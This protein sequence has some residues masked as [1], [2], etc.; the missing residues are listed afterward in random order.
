MPWPV[1]RSWRAAPRGGRGSRP[2]GAW[3]RGAISGA[4]AFRENEHEHVQE[5]HERN[6]RV[7]NELESKRAAR[8]EEDHRKQVPANVEG[9]GV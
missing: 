9:A 6:E 8:S 2:W 1:A 3:C 4:A 5:S 7:C